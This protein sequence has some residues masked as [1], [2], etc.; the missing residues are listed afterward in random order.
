MKL[1]LTGT[2]AEFNEL[3]KTIEQN[4]LF[5]DGYRKPQVGG[6]PKYKP[7]GAKYDPIAGEQLLQYIDIDVLTLKQMI[8]KLK[9]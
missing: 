1:R 9:P 4:K 6:N 5:F 8:K 2:Q 7:G 3:G